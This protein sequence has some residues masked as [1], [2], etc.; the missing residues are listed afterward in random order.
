MEHY[1]AKKS[2][3]LQQNQLGLTSTNKASL[4][5][6]GKESPQAMTKLSHILLASPAAKKESPQL[7][8]SRNWLA[9]SKPAFQPRSRVVV[10][11]VSSEWVQK[12]QL[13]PVLQSKVAKRAWMRI[14]LCRRSRVPPTLTAFSHTLR[15]ARLK[16]IKMAILSKEMIARVQVFG[17]GLFLRRTTK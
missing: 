1:S 17:S 4:L 6:I 15:L 8:T 11:S 10:G 7:T 14:E 16:K 9:L 5:A 13:R 3:L 2:V 12:R